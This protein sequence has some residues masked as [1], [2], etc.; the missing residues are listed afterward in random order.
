VRHLN[1]ALVVLMAFLDGRYVFHIY[2]I[3]DS[4]IYSKYH[5]AVALLQECLSELIILSFD[6]DVTYLFNIRI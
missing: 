3:L 4:C 5:M 2:I 6:I 1:E